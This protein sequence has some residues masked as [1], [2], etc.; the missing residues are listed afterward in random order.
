[1]T[2]TNDSWT[3]RELL[4]QLG[5]GTAA[6]AASHL[7]A[8]LAQAQAG[9]SA[10]PLQLP[11]QL[12]SLVH[13]IGISVRDV[14]KSAEF[15]SRVFGGSNVYGEK[16]PAVRYFIAFK[17]GDASVDAGDIAIGKLGTLGSQGKTE[18]LI[19]HLCVEAVSHEG[20]AWRAALQKEGLKALPSGGIF[21]DKDNI[22]I[23]VAGAR[24][25][26]MSTGAVTRMPSL[27]DG[28]ALVKSTGFDHVMLRVG[29]PQA[30]AVFYGKIFGL[31]PSGR[32]KDVVWFT[33]KDK[34]RLGLRKTVAGE[35]PGVDTYGV[36]VAAF[37]RAR[38][39]DALQKLG[40]TVEAKRGDEPAGMVRFAD[41]D[42]IKAVLTSA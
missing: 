27:Y 36:K 1:M 42:G 10:P 3:R 24:A 16:E 6:M 41:I 20:A 30:A 15:Y 18:P 2:S 38:L 28:P 5:F 26:Q 11:L 14:L 37:E 7:L 8:Q 19:D 17:P 35:Q 39:V 4:R 23:Q 13:H 22:A 9:A 34:V 32:E 33:D 40:A 21:F 29:D 12:T 25:E 31:Q